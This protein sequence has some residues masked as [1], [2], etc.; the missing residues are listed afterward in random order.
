VAEAKLVDLTAK[1]ERRRHYE[2][3][4]I[5]SPSLADPAAK[6]LSD[7]N[8]KL[9]GDQG[10]TMLRQDTWGKKKMAYEIE[11]HAMGSYFFFRYITN[12]ACINALERSLKLDANVL[13]YKT[14]VLSD[15]L[16][17]ADQKKLI[18]AAPAQET[19]APAYRRG[20][21]EWRPPRRGFDDDRKRG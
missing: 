6:E 3:V 17:D 18:D 19:T 20:E 11:K 2:T 1:N 12:A 10:G 8:A 21:E 15:V 16:A 9:V 5:V 13:R 7:K 4:F 14:V